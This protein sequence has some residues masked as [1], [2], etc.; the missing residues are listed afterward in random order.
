MKLLSEKDEI[1]SSQKQEGKQAPS[2][3]LGI[4]TENPA[5]TDT[6]HSFLLL[7][8]SAIGNIM[9]TELGGQFMAAVTV[10]YLM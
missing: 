2:E 1:L 4:Q 8:D 3:W 10:I 9:A 7:S 6:P 5:T